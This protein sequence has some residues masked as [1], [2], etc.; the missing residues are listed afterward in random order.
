MRRLMRGTTDS[1]TA[2]ICAAM[3]AGIF[4]AVMAPRCAAGEPASGCGELPLAT[5]VQAICT[6]KRYLESKSEFCVGVSDFSITAEA[7]GW[8][9]LVSVL[10]TNWERDPRCTGD[11]LEISQ[12]TGQL[13]R[14]EYLKW[15]YSE[16]EQPGIARRDR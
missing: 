2:T 1:S 8:S 7:N 9:W 16:V 13:I 4:L 6:A 5:Q 12:R 3:L 14:W 15:P 11:R 10:P